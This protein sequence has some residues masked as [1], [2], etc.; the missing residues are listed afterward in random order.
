[1]MVQQRNIMKAIITQRIDFSIFSTL[2]RQ[3]VVFFIK[4]AQRLRDI[5]ERIIEGGDVVS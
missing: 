5:R 2:H 4:L 3:F 1:M